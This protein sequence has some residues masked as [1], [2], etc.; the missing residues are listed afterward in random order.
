VD[1]GKV[2]CTKARSFD[3]NRFANDP[4]K[5]SNIHLALEHLKQLLEL[6]EVNFLLFLNSG[7]VK[8]ARLEH[9]VPPIKTSNFFSQKL[10]ASNN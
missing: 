5:L 7:E 10:L 1:G 4:I 8:I 3:R 2:H 9:F 6:D